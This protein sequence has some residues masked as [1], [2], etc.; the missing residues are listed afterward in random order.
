MT[1]GLSLC[2]ENFEQ[3][4]AKNAKAEKKLYPSRPSRPSVQIFHPSIMTEGL[5]LCHDE[6]ES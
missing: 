6:E 3:K 5:S 1:K 2:R 4:H